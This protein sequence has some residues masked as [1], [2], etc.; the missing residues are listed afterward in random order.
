MT[1]TVQRSER[2]TAGQVGKLGVLAV[3]STLDPFTLCV[4]VPAVP[5]IAA[6][7]AGNDH[8]VLMAQVLLVGPFVAQ[9]VGPPIVGRLVGRF[10]RRLPL[11]VALAVLGAAGT[12]GWWVEAFWTFLAC[13]IACGFASSAIATVCTTLAGDY[14]HGRM[15]DVAISWLGITPSLGSVVA[16]LAAGYLASTGGWHLP[17]L[18]FTLAF[19][20]LLFAAW[21]LDEPATVGGAASGGGK[22]RLPP[23]VV[24]VAFWMLLAGVAT[25]LSS[26]ELPFL[27]GSLGMTDPSIPSTILGTGAVAATIGAA[28]YPWLKPRLGQRGLMAAL[29]LVIGLSLVCA[30]L[31]RALPLLWAT[32]MALSLGMGLVV[33]TFTGAVMPLV[34]TE[35]RPRAIGLVVSAMFAGW[36]LTPFIVGPIR[37]LVGDAG[38]FGALGCF[39]ALIGLFHLLQ[40]RQPLRVARA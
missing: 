3:A 7:F 9:I 17:F 18:L 23:A 36:F 1:T 5:G 33:P 19:P 40:A 6:H 10:G 12:A 31:V 29:F 15:R 22:E 34:S 38:V 28:L 32:M 35:A 37:A 20:I 24:G 11:L 26:V 39:F 4:M 16:L 30:S 2:S 13:R 25:I 21:L 27:M 14:F 8:A